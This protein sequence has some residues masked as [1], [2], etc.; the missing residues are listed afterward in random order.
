[1]GAMNRRLSK[2]PATLRIL[3]AVAT[4][5]KVIISSL[6][7]QMVLRICITLNLRITVD[8]PSLLTRVPV[9]WLTSLPPAELWSVTS[10]SCLWPTRG[11]FRN[12]TI[13]C[14]RLRPSE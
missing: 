5:L 2:W 1:M 6:I 13:E 14:V 4:S 7:V 10:G 12:W 3:L 9:L 11:L 8:V